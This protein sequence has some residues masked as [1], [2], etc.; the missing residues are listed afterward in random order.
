MRLTEFLSNFFEE[1]RSTLH[2]TSAISPLSCFVASLG[3]IDNPMHFWN[4]AVNVYEWSIWFFGFAAE[5]VSRRKEIR[6][7][8]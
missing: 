1:L 2:I 5:L 7:M 8:S 3:E 6:D 4:S